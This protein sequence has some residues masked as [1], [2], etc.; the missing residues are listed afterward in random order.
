MLLKTLLFFLNNI[1]AYIFSFNNPD[2]KYFSNS[3]DAN[4]IFVNDKRYATSIDLVQSPLYKSGTM[5]AIGSNALSYEETLKRIILKKTN[6]NDLTQIFKIIR[7]ASG[8]HLL[9]HKETCMGYDNK[10]NFLIM[11]NCDEVGNIIEANIY[12][13]TI[14]PFN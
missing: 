4:L 8:N 13:N 12:N 3:T 7:L 1:Y 9:Q 10:S 6:H 14:D 5:L 2:L 11:V